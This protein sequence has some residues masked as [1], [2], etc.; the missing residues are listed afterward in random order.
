MT[1]PGRSARP[2]VGFISTWPVYQ[3]ATFDRHAPA[4]MQGIASAAA[5]HDCDLL[6]AAGVISTQEGLRWR[7]VWPVPADDTDLIPVGPWNTDGLIVALD[8]LTHAQSEYVGDL[9]RSGFPIVFT[10][11]EAPGICVVADNRGGIR[12]A[13]EHL[14][15]HGHRDIGFIA[16]KQHR[17]GDSAE[18]LE[19]F[20]ESM[21]AAGLR[22][23]ERLIAYGEHRRDGGYGAMTRILGD[24]A[25]FSAIVASNDL[26]CIGAMDAL[27]ERGRRVPHDVAVIGFD[28]ILDARSHDPALTTI[29]LPTFALGQQA[30]VTVL[31]RISGAGGPDVVVAPTRLIVRR[32]CGCSLE[33]TVRPRAEAVSTDPTG[34]LV[35]AM[36]SAAYAEANHA[37]E[38]ELRDE[39]QRLLA[40]ILEAAG[41]GTDPQALLL[42]LT[43]VLESAEARGDD[44]HLWQSAVSALYRER[45]LLGRA[46][47]PLDEAAIL[48][49]ADIA[50]STI[51]ERAQRRTTSVLLEHMD[52]RSRLGLLTSQLLAAHEIPETTRILGE[53]LPGLGVRDLLACRFLDDGEDPGDVSEIL[54]ATGI[55][56]AESGR[57]LLTREFPPT[58]LYPRD[59]PI[60]MLVLP[61]QMGAAARGFVAMTTSDLEVAAAIVVNLGAAIR[62]SELYAEAT[63]GRRMAEDANRVKSRFLS[64]VGHELRTPLSVVIGLSDLVLREARQDEELPPSLLADLERLG[65]S[66]AHLGQLISDVLDLA[67]GET[68][69]LRLR[70]ASVDLSEALKEAVTVAAEM[71]EAGGLDFEA[72]VPASGPSV[73]GDATRLRQIVLNLVSNAVKFTPSGQVTLELIESDGLVTVTVT[74]TGIGIPADDQTVIFSGFSGAPRIPV[75]GRSGLG[76]GLTIASDLVALHGGHL[77]VRSPIEAGHGSAF[78]FSLPV[79]DGTEPDTLGSGLGEDTATAALKSV[80]GDAPTIPNVLIVDDDPGLVDVH[81]RLV[82]EAGARPLRASSGHE[83]LEVLRAEPVDLVML[84]LG[85]E[86]GDGHEVLRAMRD[87]PETRNTAVIIV[88]GQD[89]GEDDLAELDRGVIAIVSK[90]ILG[91]TETRA[92]IEAA[93]AHR[94]LLGASARQV[95]RR[96]ALYIDH[97][98][99][100][101][102]TREDVAREVAI[103]SDYLTD[104]FRQELG[105]TPMT[106]LTRCRIRH[107]R[108]LLETSDE[109]VT[110]IA[111]VVGFSDASH[112]TRTF[113]REVGVSPRA[114]RQAGRN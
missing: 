79:L 39:C 88:T 43:D 58:D 72:R 65:E 64:T 12:T 71:A 35:E 57:T 13:V 9:Q 70:L 96:A 22:A 90:G 114:Y 55:E 15:E 32:S 48:A 108:E 1:D 51:A 10:A 50:R 109:Q 75:H 103:S 111:L 54:L 46:A 77:E 59:E 14:I 99:V 2:V 93:L 82:V 16:G 69:R 86:D 47:G 87:A 8:D 37:T 26:S 112:F 62:S 34:A 91:T 18:R 31:Q 83:A 25:S 28:D 38:D 56:G 20:I 104:C 3:G 33:R 42:A 40:A 27:A 6:M 84:D 81:A 53:Q 102:I 17:G 110:T 30:L 105:V 100:E 36:A 4:L 98:H 19:A 76:I 74:D 44:P 113:R 60:G 95:V 97:H 45:V 92:R 5:E 85:M 78:S 23:D 49:T 52:T 63:A 107:A 89:L 66:A 41:P 24:G 61:L 94:R 101:P 67:S 7:S 73:R 29:R 106:F 11:P 68:G 21:T 80:R